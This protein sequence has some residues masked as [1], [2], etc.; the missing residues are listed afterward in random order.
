MATLKTRLAAL[1][2][3]IVK[4]TSQETGFHFAPVMGIEEW[5]IAAQ[6]QQAQLI[7]DVHEVT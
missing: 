5:C 1:E 2:A 3:A 7:K 6:L 4:P